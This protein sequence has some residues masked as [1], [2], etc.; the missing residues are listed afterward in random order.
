MYPILKAKDMDKTDIIVVD[1][2][3]LVGELTRNV[4]EHSGFS[5]RLVPDSRNALSLIGQ[6]SPKLVIADIML[7][8]I[9]GLELCNRIT[10]DPAL[11]GVKVMIMSA[12]AFDTEI[13]RARAFGALHFLV[14]PFSKEELLDAVNA[15]LCRREPS[16]RAS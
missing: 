8:G 11:A 6:T 7:P 10:S 13:R 4:L 2:D 1:D 3:K 16:P 9:S 14:K 5:V 15:L 12:K